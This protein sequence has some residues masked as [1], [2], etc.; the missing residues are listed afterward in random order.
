[1][2]HDSSTATFDLEG[3]KRS[4]QAKQ[5][6]PIDSTE[7]EN[8]KLVYCVYKTGNSGSSNSQSCNFEL[9]QVQKE[10]PSSRKSKQ[11]TNCPHTDKKHYAKGLCST[12][13]HKSGR[14]KKA[15]ACAHNNEV[16][17][18]KGCCQECYVQY[19]SKRGRKA[20]RGKKVPQTTNLTIKISDFE[21]FT[22][23]IVM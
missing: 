20:N 22:T 8:L 5:T 2:T 16:H 11:V 10:G 13:Y 12:C 3:L 17:Y 14:T 15:W 9:I 7:P 21:E 18:A 19:H 1:M 6:K 23:K 4:R